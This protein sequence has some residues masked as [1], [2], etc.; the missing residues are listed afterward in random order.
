MPLIRYDIGDYAEVGAPCPCGRGLPVI[1]RIYGRRQNM[2]VLPGG[3][4]RWPLLS[5]DDIRHLRQL[6]PISQYQFAQKYLEHLELR[7][8]GERAFT[9]EEK[10]KLGTWVQ[11]KFAYPFA[12]TITE[13]DS[14]PRTRA[15]KFEDFVSE[16]PRRVA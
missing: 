5:S 12:V 2:L 6:A 11:E 7:L 10:G 9:A 8:V 15:G 4:E 13:L 1:K 3:E 16:I 14:L